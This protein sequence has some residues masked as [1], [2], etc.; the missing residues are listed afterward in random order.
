MPMTTGFLTGN[1]ASRHTTGEP[2]EA[3]E[4]RLDRERVE[5]EDARAQIRRGECW[6]AQDPEVAAWL[7]DPVSNPRPQRRRPEPG[8]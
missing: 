3:R 4:A 7:R 8:F 1:F 2:A 6:N 5:L